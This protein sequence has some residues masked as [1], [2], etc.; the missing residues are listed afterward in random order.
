MI[1]INSGPEWFYGFNALFNVLFSLVTF[2]IS[3]L[4]YRVYR[5]LKQRKYYYLF[6][7]F[8][9]ISLAFGLTAAGSFLMHLGFYERIISILDM[10]DVI[11]LGQMTLMLLAYTMLLLASMNVKSRRLIA[12]VI[13]LMV[14]FIVFSYQYYLKFHMV[15]F[16]LLFFLAGNFYLNYRKRKSLSSALVFIGFYFLMLSQLFFLFTA[17]FSTNFYIAGQMFQL[18]GFSALFFMLLRVTRRS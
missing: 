4:S 6:A 3:M 5:F 12:F 13:S 14:L 7:S 1:V 11:F 10:F 8:L 2:F 17:Q 18:V 15:L 9:L 16:L